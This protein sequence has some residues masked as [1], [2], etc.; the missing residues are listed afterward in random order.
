MR[1]RREE[2]GVEMESEGGGRVG[3]EGGDGGEGERG[4]VDLGGF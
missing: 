4:A 3:G 2:D 1:W